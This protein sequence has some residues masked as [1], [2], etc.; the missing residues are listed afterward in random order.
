[1]PRKTHIQKGEPTCQSG[2][3][4]LRNPDRPGYTV[5]AAL[6]L[7]TCAGCGVQFETRNRSER[8]HS[9]TCRN[10]AKM[11]RYRAGLLA[12]EQAASLAQAQATVQARR[13]AFTPPDTLVSVEKLLRPGQ[14][15]VL[16][17]R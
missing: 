3:R 13:E 2:P 4:R 15:T 9:H 6:L 1:M 10:A 5:S 8:Y 17:R 12:R 14:G 16:W 11:R 7:N